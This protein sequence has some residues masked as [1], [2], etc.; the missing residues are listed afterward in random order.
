MPFLTPLER[1]NVRNYKYKG[2]DSSLIYQH[3]LSP[4]AQFFVDLTPNWVAP[5][6]ITFVG[7]MFPFAATVLTLLY[8]PTL[9]AATQ[10]A[11]LCCFTGV[12]VFIYQTMDNMDGKQAR[13]TGS[14][15]PFGMLFD[16]GCDALNASMTPVAVCGVF[17]TG[18][19]TRIF[20]CYCCSFLPFYLQTW[21]EHYVGEMVLPIVNG[22]TE[23]L[24][25]TAFGALF[26]A[27]V[28]SS[29]WH[30]PVATL[31]PEVLRLLGPHIH[32]LLLACGWAVQGS[33]EGTM[34]LTPFTL[35]CMLAA[36][37]CLLNSVAPIWT[38]RNAL[39]K[40]GEGRLM[41]RA[42]IDLL[43]FYIFLLS[44]FSA[45]LFSPVA[46]RKYPLVFV[47]AMGA[48]FVE[49]L[50]HIMLTHI[51]HSSMAPTARLLLWTMPVLALVSVGSYYDAKQRASSMGRGGDNLA[52]EEFETVFLFA[53]AAGGLIY[54]LYV[55]SAVSREMLD[56][57][58]IHMF[59]LQPRPPA[60]KLL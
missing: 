44:A 30:T 1:E 16:H 35:Y 2:C 28:G 43:P 15:S 29:W 51:A 53:Y 33:V 34:L 18:W 12:A 46:L 41:A 60:G 42:V 22:P 50:I 39:K 6:L 56:V 45:A 32:D 49:T 19:N 24:L 13:K 57:L 3:V 52:S 8:N 7:L 31:S 11:W 54:T 27:L 37:L 48:S 58:N 40:R 47:T 38:V 20:L 17:G 59:S 4:L 36:V 26:T 9:E 55:I 5:N 10:P 21:E 25:L 23:G 14:S